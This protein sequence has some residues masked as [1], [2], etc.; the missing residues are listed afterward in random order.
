LELIV[1]N[2]TLYDL[3]RQALISVLNYLKELISQ[4]E[5]FT[6]T[7]RLKPI[8]EKDR[9]RGL[10]R[11]FDID[12]GQILVAHMDEIE[13]L[14]QVKK[15]SEFLDILVKDENSEIKVRKITSDYL[16]TLFYTYAS[17]QAFPKYSQKGFDQ[18]YLVLEH[19]MY[20]TLRYRS[21][22]P[23]YNFHMT[24][25]R[26]RIDNDFVIRKIKSDEYVLV[27]KQ[28]PHEVYSL[29]YAIEFSSTIFEYNVKSGPKLDRTITFLRLYKQGAISYSEVYDTPAVDL[30][31]GMSIK[32]KSRSSQRFPEFHLNQNDIKRLRRFYSDFIDIYN[33]IEEHSFFYIAIDR[34]NSSLEEM[35]SADKIIDLSIALEA[36]FS[37]SSEDLTYKLRIRV[38]V[39]LGIDYNPNFL[40]DFIGKAYGIRSNLVHGKLGKKT[41]GSVIVTSSKK[42]NL[43]GVAN[44]LEQITRLSIRRMLSLS[45][46]YDYKQENEFL[47]KVID[48]VAIGYPRSILGF[49]KI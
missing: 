40:Y 7:T 6:Q 20:G 45:K 39:L 38:S 41:T 43:N 16:N 10:E 32:S 11:Y 9:F 13:N 3:S 18:S 27:A 17:I 24:A 19:Y 48:K 8:I 33:K 37:T 1:R 23:L 30:A 25:S 46:Y 2:E 5:R 21:F 36:L 35:E 29:R 4:G 34:F 31:L 26:I 14:P 28:S 47:N 15:L 42:Y 49:Q 12:K 22:V 44:E